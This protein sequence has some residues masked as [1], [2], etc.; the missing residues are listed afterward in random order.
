LD[1]YGVEIASYDTL[2][3]CLHTDLSAINVIYML[4]SFK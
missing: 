4:A 3:Q 2:F 1:P